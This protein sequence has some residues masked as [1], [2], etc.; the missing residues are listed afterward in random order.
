MEPQLEDL[1]FAGQPGSDM[2]PYDRRIDAAG[3]R[4]LATRPLGRQLE[5]GY[6]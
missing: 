4:V 1:T 2:H 5:F 6:D 3:R